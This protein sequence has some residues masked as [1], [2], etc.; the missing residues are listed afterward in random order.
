MNY[1]IEVFSENHIAE[2]FSCGDEN[3]DVFLKKNAL[4]YQRKNIAKTY[5]IIE[6]N[7]DN[8]Q[9]NH[10]LI[11]GFYTLSVTSVLPAE[12]GMRWP[13]HP[14]PVALLARLARDLTQKKRGLGEI[15]FADAA[16]RVVEVSKITGCHAL[17]TDAKNSAAADFYKRFGM[18]P[19]H[20]HHLKLFLPL[21]TLR[22]AIEK[23]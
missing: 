8:I 21:D 23:T 2:K 11:L 14:V 16:M 22:S 18:I 13:K 12:V 3:L 5:V 20:S 4:H 15:L 9:I 19:F 10:K 1:K 17:V 7:S 6:D